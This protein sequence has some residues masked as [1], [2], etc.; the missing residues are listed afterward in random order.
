M[1]L[2]SASALADAAAA[3]AV[4]DAADYA[5]EKAWLAF[6]TFRNQ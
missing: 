2:E 3:A 1:G 4:L 5:D 6:C